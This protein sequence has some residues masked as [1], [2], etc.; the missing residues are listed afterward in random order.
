MGQ[1][2]VFKFR[3]LAGK[4]F[5]VLRLFSD[6]MIEEADILMLPCEEDHRSW[7]IN[8]S[9]INRATYFLLSSSD[10]ISH[11]ERSEEEQ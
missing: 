6:Q 9:V 4:R 7:K 3:S 8:E 10:L 2:R 5:L 1:L 11:V